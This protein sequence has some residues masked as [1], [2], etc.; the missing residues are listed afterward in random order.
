MP[1]L[2][3]IALQ[4]L[5]STA[6]G[7]IPNGAGTMVWWFRIRVSTA[8]SSTSASPVSVIALPGP[9][10]C[11]ALGG[12]PQK[13]VGVRQPCRRSPTWYRYIGALEPAWNIAASC[14]WG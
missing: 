3:L 2:C 6:L 10:L 8:P 7:S 4:V 14:I 13:T 12:I 9:K 11:L 1:L 5:T